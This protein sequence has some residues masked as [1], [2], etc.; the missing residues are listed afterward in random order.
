MY[1]LKIPIEF[2]SNFAGQKK[3]TNYRN[4][5]ALISR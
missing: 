5:N 4:E 2:L 1:I 3:D